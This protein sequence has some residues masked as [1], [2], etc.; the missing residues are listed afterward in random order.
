MKIEISEPNNTSHSRIFFVGDILFNSDFWDSQPFSKELEKHINSAK[1]SV[2]NL[3]APLK[4]GDAIPKSGPVLSITE[5]TINLLSNDFDAVS[6]ANNHIMDYGEAGLKKTIERCDEKGVSTF[7]AGLNLN[8]ALQPVE[9]QIGETLIGIFGV[10]EHELMIA[11]KNKAGALWARTPAITDLIKQKSKKHDIKILL[12][13]GGLEYVPIPPRSWRDLLHGFADIG[14]DAI[15]AH[16]PHCAQGWEIKGTTPIFYSLGNFLMYNDRFSATEWCY[17]VDLKIADKEVESASIIPLKAENG[18]VKNIENSTSS[19]FLEYLTEVSKWLKDDR[20]YN[21]Y[22]R[23]VALQRY[24]YYKKI[25]GRFNRGI[26]GALTEEPYYYILNTVKRKILEKDFR[27]KQEIDF[28]NKFRNESVRNT[29]L[30]AI[31]LKVG[32]EENDLTDT[33]KREIEKWSEY[34]KGRKSKTKIEKIKNL[35]N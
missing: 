25:L 22:W 29:M 6:L 1:I 7:G 11:A 33:I 20:I 32:L 24:D 4:S 15:V 17:G 8:K 35:I 13:H 34:Y 16:H 9:F 10:S 31:D 2:G 27:I 19:D 5:E 23:N 21:K 30:T 12:A 28:T 14:L 3:E 26:L 18:K